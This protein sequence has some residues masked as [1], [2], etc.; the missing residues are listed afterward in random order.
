VI[1]DGA[2]RGL[3]LQ[4]AVERPD[5]QIVALGSVDGAASAMSLFDA[6]GRQI[7]AAV[8]TAAPERVTWSPDRSAVLVV[9]NDGAAYHYYVAQVDGQVREITEGF[10]GALSVEWVGG[11]APVVQAA[12]SGGA[13]VQSR[14]GLHI[15][16]GV[17]VVAPAGVN[18]RAA[19]STQAQVLASMKIYESLVIV[20]GP[21][22]GEGLIWWQVKTGGGVVGW[23][24]EG[25]RDVQLLSLNAR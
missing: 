4:D 13:L 16:G 18:L 11:T 17:Q 2:G 24:A 25:A 6:N 20:G 22:E 7:S 14:Y 9:V 3:W 19:P 15:N 23:A 21:V 5:G 8:G 10:A 12:P 1:L